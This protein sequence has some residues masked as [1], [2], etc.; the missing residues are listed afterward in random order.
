MT[1]VCAEHNQDGTHS[2]ITATSIAAVTGTFS[3]VVSDFGTT[4]PAI[5]AENTFDFVAS[6]GV[7]TADSVGVN[8]N[9]SMTAMV[10]YINGRRIAIS[11]ITAHAFTASKDTYIDVLD[12]ADGTGTV[13]YTEATTNAASPA[14][15][16]NSIRICIIQAAATITATTKVNQGQE[17]RVF[18][19]ASSIPYAVTDSLGNLICPRDSMKR[20]LGYRQVIANQ[21]SITTIV[22]ITGLSVPFIADGVTKVKATLKVGVSGSVAG[23]LAQ[24]SLKEGATIFDQNDIYVASTS[25]RPQITLSKVH[26]PTAG[27]HT[28]KGTLQRLTGTGT[29]IMD[30]NGGGGIP[31]LMIERA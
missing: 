4:L 30:V 14:L 27:L 24:P 31:Y 18:P 15:A 9:A 17:D 6:G 21:G 25:Q 10:C 12:N 5:R 13:V 28:Y 16:V 1:G 3:G 26:T 20:T 23:D 22:D 7:W 8:L 2:A 11:A 29:L 19:I